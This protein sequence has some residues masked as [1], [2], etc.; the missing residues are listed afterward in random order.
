MVP[1]S[2]IAAATARLSPS[3]LTVFILCVA[4]S[5]LLSGHSVSA[6]LVYDRLL[7][8]QIRSTMEIYQVKW[9]DF[10]FFPPPMMHTLYQ[11]AQFVNYFEG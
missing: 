3:H 1:V 10:N 6:A 2:G 7:L 4:L 8:L 9:N 5:A 11:Q